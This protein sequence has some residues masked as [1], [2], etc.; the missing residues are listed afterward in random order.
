[1]AKKIRQLS[2]NMINK[3]VL[4]SYVIN[5]F[6]KSNLRIEIFIN[7]ALQNYKHSGK[8]KKMSRME[9]IKLKKLHWI[10]DIFTF[11]V[12]NVMYFAVKSYIS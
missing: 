7:I 5:I 11:I 1:M 6:S 12:T 2:M 10:F 8:K 4:R 3:R 9:K